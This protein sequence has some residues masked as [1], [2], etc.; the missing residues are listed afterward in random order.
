VTFRA[1]GILFSVGPPE[2]LTAAERVALERLDPPGDASGSEPFRLCLEP[3]SPWTSDDPE[4]YPRF[5]PPVQRWSGGR[6]LASHHSFTA[7]IHPAEAWARVHRREE[8]AYPLEAVVRTAMLARLPLVGGLPLHAAGVVAPEGG[9]AFFGPSGAGKTTLADTSPHPVLSD[10]LVAV[11]PGEPPS[12]VRSGFWGEAG[13]GGR[14]AGAPL[15]ALVSLQQAAA[16]DLEPLAPIEAMRVLAA[17][18]PVPLAVPLWS[19]AL[20]VARSLVTRVPVFRMAWVREAPPWDRLA[21]ALR[22]VPG[23]G[24]KG[25]RPSG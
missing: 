14:S 11:A 1:G 21:D 9:L 22:S 8:R 20:A 5:E 7:E 25:M 6:L 10:E 15:V 19:Q 23:S 13:E 12:L 16:F 3:E 4:L 24:G 18:V 17:A 2:A